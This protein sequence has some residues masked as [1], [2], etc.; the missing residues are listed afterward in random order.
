MTAFIGKAGQDKYELVIK[1]ERKSLSKYARG[2]SISDCVPDF[3]DPHSFTIDTL[4]K[5]L[6]IQFI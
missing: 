4:K 6:M 3:T 2:L 5:K 1:L